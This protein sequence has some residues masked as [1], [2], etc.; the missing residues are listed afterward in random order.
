MTI[1]VIDGMGGGIGEEI[2]RQIRKSFPEE[3]VII[4]LGANA[5]ATDRMLK[6]KASKGASAKTRLRSAFN[7]RI[8]LLDRLGLFFQTR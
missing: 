6:A 1:A 7:R 5:L 8:L 2:V 3:T 4:A